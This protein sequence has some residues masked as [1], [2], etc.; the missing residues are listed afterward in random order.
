MLKYK[1][2]K[3]KPYKKTVTILSPD[4]GKRE[5]KEILV[6]DAY[7]LIKDNGDSIVGDTKLMQS[8]GV[9]IP[10]DAPEY[11]SDTT[12]SKIV[13]KVVQ[14]GEE[15][16]EDGDEDKTNSKEGL[17]KVTNNSKGN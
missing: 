7:I 9:S 11:K 6:K 5:E 2:F 13:T 17:I 16:E 10:N 3:Y 4:G 14:I 15:V 1:I 8:F 12:E